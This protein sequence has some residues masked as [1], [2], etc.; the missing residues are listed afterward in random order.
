MNKPKRTFIIAPFRAAFDI[1][2]KENGLK[3]DKSIRWIHCNQTRMNMWG[4]G[5]DC[6]IIWID[7]DSRGTFKWNASVALKIS[8]DVNILVNHGANLV[9]AILDT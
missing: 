8:E 1:Y 9:Y 4:F 6:Q 7:G 5:K 2:C 3:G